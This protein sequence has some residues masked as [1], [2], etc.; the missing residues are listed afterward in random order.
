MALGLEGKAAMMTGG[1]GGICKAS[2][3]LAHRRR[4]T[5]H[6]LCT[7]WRRLAHAA[8][9]I[10]GKTGKDVLTAFMTGESAVRVVRPPT[11]TD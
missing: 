9:D 2:A 7:P 5:H 10:R 11:A 1:S 3:L 4:C 6:D 8:D